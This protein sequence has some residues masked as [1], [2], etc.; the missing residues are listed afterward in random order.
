MWSLRKI[1]EGGFC[2]P[3]SI[4]LT[5]LHGLFCMALTVPFMMLHE[6][7]LLDKQYDIAWAQQLVE[8]VDLNS[9][10]LTSTTSFLATALFLMLS[11]R[12]DRTSSRYWEGRRLI[13]DLQASV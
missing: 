1:L 3:V 10:S 11:F 9:A 8:Y 6:G 2:R 13:G 7:A 5:G 12:I 4:Y